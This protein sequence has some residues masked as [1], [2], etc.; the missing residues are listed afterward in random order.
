M[1][2]ERRHIAE[3]VAFDLANDAESAG[4]LGLYGANFERDWFV[5]L[6]RVDSERCP[7]VE[8]G[9]RR[10]NVTRTRMIG[11]EEMMKDGRIGIAK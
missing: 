9:V 1:R 5:L 11:K 6:A 2:R 10:W 4:K 7:R 3:R 8:N